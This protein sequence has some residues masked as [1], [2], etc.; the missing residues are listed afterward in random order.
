MPVS[1]PLLPSSPT[2]DEESGGGNGFVSIL[3]YRKA[4]DS[5]KQKAAWYYFE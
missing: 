5:P 3:G 4:E 1:R 2:P